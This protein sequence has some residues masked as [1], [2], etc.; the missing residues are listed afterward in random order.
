MSI[1]LRLD[2]EQSRRVEELARDLKV[3]PT[4]LAKAA[5]NDLVSRSADDFVRAIQHVLDKNRELY[6]RLA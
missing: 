5:I 3:D 4:E 1:T 6:R 2:D